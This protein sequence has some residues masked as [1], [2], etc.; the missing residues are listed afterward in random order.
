MIA[1]TLAANAEDVSGHGDLAKGPWLSKNHHKVFGKA[2]GA[3][4]YFSSNVGS[5]L[6]ELLNKRAAPSLDIY[7]FGV[8]TGTRMREFAR[9]VRGF[10]RMWGFDS[11]TGFPDETQGVWTPNKHWAQGGNSASDAMRLWD[12]EQ[13]FRKLRARIGYEKTVFIAGYY[14]ESLS[15][16]LRAQRPFAPALIVD[17]DCDLYVSTVQA[18]RWVFASGLVLPG[19]TL[20]RYD[21]WPVNATQVTARDRNRYR[22]LGR[23]P[24]PEVWGQ[25]KSHID[26]TGEFQIEWRRLSRNVFQVASLG[27]RAT[28]ALD[29]SSSEASC[30]TKPCW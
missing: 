28:S 23:K 3:P 20:F 1:S 6:I 27:Q 25:M 30:L 5:W 2:G 24:P 14:N 7:E 10:G 4:V 8:Y 19:I 9:K 22:K 12:K 15:P 29:A 11:F 16:Q 13:L 17:L 21:D 26:V 18:L